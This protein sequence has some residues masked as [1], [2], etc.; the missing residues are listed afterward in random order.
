MFNDTV[1]MCG[2]GC[3]KGRCWWR[4]T[5]YVLNIELP[6]GIGFVQSAT[7]GDFVCLEVVQGMEFTKC[8]YNTYFHEPH[9]A[10]P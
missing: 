7:T 5:L 8:Y 2:T 4:Y 1:N 6:V 9:I 10:L 3:V